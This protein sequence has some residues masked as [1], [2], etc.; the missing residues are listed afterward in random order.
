VQQA[1]GNWV[2][3][4]DPNQA[5]YETFTTAS[6]RFLREFLVEQGVEARELPNSGRSTQ[7]IMD[8]A[9]SLVDWTR[10]HHPVAALRD[11]LTP[12]LIEPTPPGDPSRTR[13]MTP[14]ASNSW[15]GSS[16]QKRSWVL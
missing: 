2:R 5:I 13:P 1:I 12:P 9:N 4:G 15:T 8:L 14:P 10:S 3:V 16:R 6:P 11:A 7:S